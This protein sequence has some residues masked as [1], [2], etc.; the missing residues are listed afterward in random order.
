[1]SIT[2]LYQQLIIFP[3]SKVHLT[4]SSVFSHKWA[5]SHV[6]LVDIVVAKISTFLQV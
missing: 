5:R 4:R 3:K 1:M 6:T 2:F